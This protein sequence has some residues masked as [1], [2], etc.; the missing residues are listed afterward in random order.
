M[1][2]SQKK[3]KE[4]AKRMSYVVTETGIVEN[5]ESEEDT[6]QTKAQQQG[7]RGTIWGETLGAKGKEAGCCMLRIFSV[8]QDSEGSRKSSLRGMMVGCQPSSLQNIPPYYR[9]C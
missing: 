8:S 4:K 7:R 1:L 3:K 5:E 2:K 9:D 6:K